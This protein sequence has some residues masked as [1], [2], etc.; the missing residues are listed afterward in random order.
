MKKAYYVILIMAFSVMLISPFLLKNR[1]KFEMAETALVKTFNLSGARIITSEINFYGSLKGNSW[2]F[3]RIKQLADELTSGL[4]VEKDSTYS[5]KEIENEQLH[6]I[7]ISGKTKDKKLV[8]AY[9]QVSRESGEQGQNAVSVTVSKDLDGSGLAGIRG[10]VSAILQKYNITPRVSS[11]ITGNLDG[12]LT[13]ESIKD[14]C[15]QM[16]KSLG[17]RKVE[18][19][20]DEKLTS[21]SA[22]SPLIRDSIKV[23]GKRINL[24]IATRYNIY[25]DK[26]YIWLATPVITIEY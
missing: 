6:K 23:N 22:Y 26:T 7:E 4:N 2:D 9:M 8:A 11:C 13:D 21:I 16:L 25:E 14:I 18:S 20:I 1:Q 3:D 12:R 5:R 24:N 17:A 15:T 10:S 19:M